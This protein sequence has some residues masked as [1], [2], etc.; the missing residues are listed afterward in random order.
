MNSLPFV[1]EERGLLDLLNTFQEGRS[2]MAI[3]CKARPGF[4]TSVS[5]F[6]SPDLEEEDSSESLLKSLFKRKKKVQDFEAGAARREAEDKVEQQAREQAWLD[7]RDSRNSLS[8]YYL[9][10]EHPIGLICLEVSRSP[11][12]HCY[13]KR[14]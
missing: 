2:H 7:A 14:C 3:V 12:S 10:D 5:H 4:S 13:S 6:T 9:D 11:L 1:S 8:N